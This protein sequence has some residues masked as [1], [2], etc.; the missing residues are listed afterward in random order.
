MQQENKRRDAKSLKELLIE[1]DNPLREKVREMRYLD[2]L[3]YIES[4][5]VNE[6]I[7]DFVD[8][9]EDDFKT[10]LSEK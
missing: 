4:V 9:D 3:R 2:F 1:T 5:S 7:S 8:I 10:Q 6:D